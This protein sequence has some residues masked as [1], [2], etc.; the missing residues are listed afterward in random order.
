MPAK[1]GKANQIKTLIDSFRYPKYGPG[2]MWQTCKQKAEAMGVTV[3]M[4][5]GMSQL[6]QMPD[7]KW[8][9]ITDNNQQY[10]VYDYIISSAPIKQLVK[11]LGAPASLSLQ[12][13]AFSLAY[14]DFIS[15]ILILKDE[16]I[17]N[18]NWIYIHDPS[19][20]VGRIQ[21][22]KSW[23]PYMV[24][25]ESMVCYG[26]EYFCFE[27][28]NLWNSSNETL[29]TLGKSELEK[30]GLGKATD[31]LDTYV[32]RQPKAYPVYDQHYQSHIDIIRKELQNFP[33]LIL[34]GRNGMHKYNNQ[35]HSMMT[36]MLAVKN[37]IAGKQIYNLWNVNQDAVYHEGGARGVEE[38][39]RKVPKR[40]TRQHLTF[41]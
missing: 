36:A 39:G 23:S 40:I 33:G 5:Q 38:G 1:P 12:K 18:D 41:E 30:I 37:I 2:Q 17:F 34:A 3:H 21:N 13:A 16:K 29:A 7:K 31:V 19:V 14:R 15:V 28:D 32:V 26:L 10:G 35:D 22:F 25:D 11:A 4:G 6:L 24:P 27:G 9:V 20:K 8:L